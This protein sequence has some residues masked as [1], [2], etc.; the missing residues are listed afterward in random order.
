MSRSPFH[1]FRLARF[2]GA[3]DVVRTSVHGMTRLL[4]LRETNR[5]CRE[6]RCI[7]TECS[8]LP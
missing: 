7:P 4:F 1:P 6:Y 8:H 2:H 5:T 3:Y